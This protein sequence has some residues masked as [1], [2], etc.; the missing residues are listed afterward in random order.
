MACRE[1]EP[2]LRVHLAERRNPLAECGKQGDIDTHWR[3]GYY[4]G[5]RL[6]LSLWLWALITLL[7]VEPAQALEPPH[8]L[9]QSY[10]FRT[11]ELHLTTVWVPLEKPSSIVSDAEFF[12]LD[13]KVA[14]SCKGKTRSRCKAL[15][16]VT[17]PSGNEAALPL[18]LLWKPRRYWNFGKEYDEMMAA[19]RA[20]S[21]AKLN[22]R[23]Y[24]WLVNRIPRD[25]LKNNASPQVQTLYLVRC[26]DLAFEP[27]ISTLGPVK[28]TVLEIT[29]DSRAQPNQRSYHI[30]D[31]AL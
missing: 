19:A 27:D 13:A 24:R 16:A 5:M 22:T 23:L 14:M 30:L 26:K 18:R 17:Y 2:L 3:E 4:L 20:K 1:G 12:L 29:Y 28:A 25:K 6:T 8:P 10:R 31:L 9:V 15:A 11:L 21:G 7:Q